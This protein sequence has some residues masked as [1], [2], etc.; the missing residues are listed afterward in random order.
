[1][2]G[3]IPQQEEQRGLGE[4]LDPSVDRPAT[5]AWAPTARPSGVHHI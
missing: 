4:A 1:V 3:S 2:R 5:V